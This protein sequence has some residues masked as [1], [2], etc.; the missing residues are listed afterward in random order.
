M[1]LRIAEKMLR[2][3][4]E[5]GLTKDDFLVDPLC[6]AVSAQSDAALVMDVQWRMALHE[7]AVEHVLT[8]TALAE[9]S[10]KVYRAY[11]LQGRPIDE[12]AAEFGIAKNYVSQIKT[13]VDRMVA[14]VE[15]RYGE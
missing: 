5:Y 12:V 8:K 1:L 7:S 14:A 10:K 15:E 11:A 2:T 13:R 4:A 3:G 6:L 9:Q